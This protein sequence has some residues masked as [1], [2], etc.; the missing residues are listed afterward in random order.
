MIQFMYVCVLIL[1]MLLGGSLASGIFCLCERRRAGIPWAKGPR[2]R[3]DSCGRQLSAIDL[4][5]VISYICLKGKCRTC[6]AEI[7]PNGCRV[8]LSWSLIFGFIAIFCAN[9]FE[10]PVLC[11]CVS[12]IGILAAILFLMCN[13]PERK[14]NESK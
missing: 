8:E 13:I 1:S 2:S 10:R 4:L 5:P 6:K 9:Q 3:C 11:I 12:V 7:P 14:E